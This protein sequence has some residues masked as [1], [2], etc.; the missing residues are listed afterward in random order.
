MMKY[1]ICTHDDVSDREQ[2]VI[3]LSELEGV[4]FSHY[5]GVV[6][7][8]SSFL[9]WYTARPGLLPHLC[10]AAF[11]GDRLVCNVFVTLAPMML[12]SGV[13]QCGL[14][15]TVMTH[16]DHRRHGLATQLLRRALAAMEA[17]GADVSL[18]YTARSEPLLGPERLY[19]GL[20]YEPRELVTRYVRPAGPVSADPAG[21]K[22]LDA[23]ARLLFEAALGGMDGWLVLN[24]DLW[25][26]RRLERPGN[27]PVALY[28]TDSGAAAAVCAGELMVSGAPSPLTVVSDLVLP[29]GNAARGDL[30][31]LLAATSPDAPV[32]ILCPESGSHAELL[33]GTGFVAAGVEVAMVRPISRKGA[34]AISAPRSEWYV[35][36]ESLIGV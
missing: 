9:R 17:A 13:V 7:S 8:T 26:W 29:N 1:H 20:G 23:S 14:V 16:P 10:Q 22:Q 33:T 34:S 24:D 27:Y 5:D 12:G 19:R 21:A 28:G 36:V 25:R 15:D 32:T 35:A 31:A 2:L 18:L 4:T 3:A 11:V 6:H 30:C